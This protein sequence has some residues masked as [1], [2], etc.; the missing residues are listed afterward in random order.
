[1]LSPIA[2]NF[3]SWSYLS[4][5]ILVVQNN[6]YIR[7]QMSLHAKLCNFVRGQGGQWW[8]VVFWKHL[9]PQKLGKHYHHNG[10][11]ACYFTRSYLHVSIVIQ[12]VL[13][14]MHGWT[15]GFIFYD[16]F[17]IVRSH[18]FLSDLWLKTHLENCNI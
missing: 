10:E 5:Y 13:Y 6:H 1:M 9:I 8:H 14:Y 2:F 12:W 16:L 11:Y 15:R 17:C 4:L 3:V 7:E 18:I